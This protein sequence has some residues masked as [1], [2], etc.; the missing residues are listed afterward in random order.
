MTILINLSVPSRIC[1]DEFYFFKLIFL[2]RHSAPA[3]SIGGAL[4]WFASHIGTARSSYGMNT[5][6]D[7]SLESD[8]TP[9]SSLTSP[10][11]HGD[12]SM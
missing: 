8:F 10:L 5:N 7:V 4:K 6:A 11:E 9:L 3:T 2:I 1:N 12:I